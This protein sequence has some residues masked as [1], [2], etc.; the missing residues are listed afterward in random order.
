MFF[1]ADIL[2]NIHESL[3]RAKIKIMAFFSRFGYIGKNK[4]C[5]ICNHYSNK[6]ASHGVIKR[7]N[8]RC[9][10]CE[11]LERHRLIWLFF[12]RKTNLFDSQ[13]KRMLHFAPEQAFVSRLSKAIGPG[14]LTVDL[15]NEAMMKMDITDLH[16]PDGSFDVIYCC[17]V[18]EHVENDIQAIRELARVLNEDGWALIVVPIQGNET[19]EDQNIRKPADRLR[20]FGQEDHVRL[21]GLDYRNRLE[22]N[23]F[24]VKEYGLNDFTSNDEQEYYGLTDQLLYF[25]TK[26]V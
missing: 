18:L 11:S 21:C 1:N 23:G 9:V 3:Y 20:V 13:Q 19:I 10:W 12:Q 6:F 17:H 25:C 8:A 16:F 24:Y 22:S 14:Y 4:K 5:P 2:N 7:A 26:R 15:H